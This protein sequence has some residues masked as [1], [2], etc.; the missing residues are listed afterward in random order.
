LLGLFSDAVT[1]TC[2]S[3]AATNVVAAK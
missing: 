1:K 3:V 2:C